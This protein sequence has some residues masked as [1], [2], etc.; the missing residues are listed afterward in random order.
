MTQEL[1]QFKRQGFKYFTDIVNWVDI[2]LHPLLIWYAILRLSDD[3]LQV[4]PTKISKILD[5]DKMMNQ[6]IL[7]VEQ[8]LITVLTFIKLFLYSRVF[9]EFGLIIR[10][11]Y[12]VF[13]KAFTFSVF[14][15]LFNLIFTF[16]YIYLGV[17]IGGFPD[18]GHGDG[19]DYMWLNHFISVF[20]Y[21]YRISIGDIEVPNAMIWET[22][23]G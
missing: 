16:L 1:I 18:S 20:L 12:E 6:Q 22:A 23:L 7:T 10:L 9:K 2:F 13:Y 11:C 4:D 8:I 14:F 17:D 3:K 19:N 5:M 15:Y 21:S